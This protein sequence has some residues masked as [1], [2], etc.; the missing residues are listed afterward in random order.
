MTVP[1]GMAEIPLM[2]GNLESQSEL[3]EQI[4]TTPNAESTPD[5]SFQAPGQVVLIL[6]GLIASGKVCL[7][8]LSR[9][10]AFLDLLRFL[11]K[12]F[13]STTI[14]ANRQFSPHLHIVCRPTFPCFADATKMI[15]GIVG[16]LRTSS[17]K[18][19]PKAFRSV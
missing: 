6:C 15:L 17:G 14:E 1:P 8:S 10:S 3:V 13:R 5:T 12:A 4:A 19:Y 11:S 16:E 7:L 9:C 18:R 2:Q